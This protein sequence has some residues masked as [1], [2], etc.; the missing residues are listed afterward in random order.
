[1]EDPAHA[2]KRAELLGWIANTRATQKR[3]GVVVASAAVIAVGLMFW[4]G[5]VGGAALAITAITA[6]CGF[7]ITGSHI[8]DWR[9]RLTEVGKPKVL[10]M[11][12]G[13]RRF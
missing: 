7:W 10:R 13:G 1:M 4:N 6:M 8:M 9:N 5:A 3:L 12:G 11:S 2:A